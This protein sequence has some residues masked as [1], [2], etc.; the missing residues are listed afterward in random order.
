R[1]LP[2]LRR[3]AFVRRA[4]DYGPAEPHPRLGATAVGARPVLVAVNCELDRDDVDL[5]R[6]IAHDV[7]ERGGG[8][9]GVR[10]LGFELASRRRASARW[11]RTRRRSRSDNPPQMPNFSPW[12][13]AYSRHS[14]RT[15]QPRQTAFASLVE[16]PRSGKNRSGSTP[17]QLA[18]SCQRRSAGPPFAA[19]G[20]ATRLS[21]RTISRIGLPP[22][23][24]QPGRPAPR[25]TPM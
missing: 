19:A 16:A 10:A 18:C 7:R 22:L 15:S 5:A 23:V 13:R 20:P 9:R 2:R 6:R 1:P 8:L 4:P 12:L 11:R 14:A 21:V 3:D 25:M 17:R 24:C